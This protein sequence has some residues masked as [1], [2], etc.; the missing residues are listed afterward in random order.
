MRK[1]ERSRRVA[2]VLSRS[3]NKAQAGARDWRP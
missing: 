1:L 3:S 2:G